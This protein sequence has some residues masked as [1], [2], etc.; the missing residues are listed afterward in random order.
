MAVSDDRKIS[1]CIPTYNRVEMTIES[2]EAVYFDERI[3][4]IIIVDDASNLEVFNELKEICDAL[5]KVSLYRNDV[6][7]D[8]YFNKKIA[9]EYSDNST[10][11][12]ILL[13]SDNI[14]DVSYL[15]KLYEIKEWDV[16]T[17]YTPSFAAPHFDFRGY[18]GLLITKENVAA[19]IDK[20]MFEVLLNAA[21]YFVHPFMYLEV[22]N[23]TVNPV[24]SDSIFQCYNWLMEEKKICVV[25]G[26]QYQHRVHSGSHYQNNVARTPQGFH[27]GIL[28]NLRQLK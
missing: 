6:N 25:P 23:P 10:D 7:K 19:Y 16:D 9:I 26:L 2:F 22:F 15:D 28:N 27:Q 20:P 14:I 8:C 12:C 4:E 24:T 5:P 1:I 18:E 21:N 17:I 13:D 3:S 11:G